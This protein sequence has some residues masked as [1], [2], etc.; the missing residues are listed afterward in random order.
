MSGQRCTEQHAAIGERQ[1]ADQ[2]PAV[3]IQAPH[4]QFKGCRHIFF[5]QRSAADVIGHLVV[6]GLDFLDQQDEPGVVERLAQLAQFLDVVNPIAV[7]T[8]HYYT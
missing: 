1:Y 4:H 5:R 7:V 3:G 2:L 8:D 6:M